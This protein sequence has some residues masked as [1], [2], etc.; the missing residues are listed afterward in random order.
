MFI[1][2]AV[3]VG[4]LV[5]LLAG[6]RLSG[7]AQVRF[8]WG[9][10]VFLGF[11]TQ[12]VL[13]SPP[14]TQRLGE[15]SSTV[16]SWLGPSIYVVSTAVVLVALL[17]NVSLPG[18]PIVALG[19]ASNFVAIAANG[20]YMPASPD[21]LAALGKVPGHDFSNGAL[22]ADPAFAPLTD[23]FAIPARLP[24]ANVFSVGDVLIG[25]GI[26]VAIAIAMRAGRP[27]PVRPGNSPVRTMD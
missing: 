17:R 4:L 6:G 10:L 12:V 24:F 25:I 3:I 2:Y 5:G 19:A 18:L 16:G 15:L 23:I 13:F 20:G 21:A 14:V 22:V 9:W 11:G 8:R 26:A 27:E 7:I 1:L